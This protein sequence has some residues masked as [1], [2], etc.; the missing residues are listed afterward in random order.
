MLPIN[1]LKKKH[2]TSVTKLFPKKFFWEMVITL[3]LQETTILFKDSKWQCS[4][5]QLLPLEFLIQWVG[6][7]PDNRY[8]RTPC[9]CSRDHN[10]RVTGLDSH[11]SW[12][13]G[14]FVQTWVLGTEATTILRREADQLLPSTENH[15]LPQN[16][17]G[18][19]TRHGKGP[20]FWNMLDV[21]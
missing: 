12:L 11:F 21:G 20:E 9:C 17:G 13:G 7:S 18:S 1:L 2:V 3:C 10:L 14:V 5:H 8:F 6:V 19:M 4:H 16:C 15:A